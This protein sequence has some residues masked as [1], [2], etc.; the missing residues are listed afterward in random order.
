ML[1]ALSL[2]AGLFLVVSVSTTSPAYAGGP[3][4][5]GTGSSYAAVAINQWAAQALSLYGLSINYETSSSVIGLDD[6][7]QSQVDFG[8]SEI[9]Y[10]TGQA[11]DTPPAGDT[12]QYLPDVAGAECLMYNLNTITGAAVTNLNLDSQVIMGIFSGQIHSWNNSQI[13]ALNPNVALP[14]A[15]I[16]VVYRT[17]AS[18]DNYIFSDYLYTLQQSAWTAYANTLNVPNG[19]TAVWPTPQGS[20]ST[21][22]YT[23]S[24][25]V[26]QSGSDNSSDYVASTNGTIT[27]VETAYAIEHNKPCAYVENSSGNFVKPSEGADAIALTNDQL[28]PDLEQNLTGVFQSPQASAY[29]ISAYSYIITQEQQMPAAKGAVL[30]QFV[31]FVACRGQIAAGELGYSPLPPNL[32]QDDFDAIRRMNGAADPGQVTASN[33]PNPYVTGALA[34]PTGDEDVGV[35][36]G[37]AVVVPSTVPS[38]GSATTAPSGHSTTSGSSAASSTAT[39]SSPSGAT[40]ATT[41]PSSSAAAGATTAT[42]IPAR[43][44]SQGA[45]VPAGAPAGVDLVRTANQVLDVPISVMKYVLWTVLLFVVV[46][47][48]PLLLARRGR[49][50]RRGSTS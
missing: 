50:R 2:L 18:G 36:P 26:G 7:A 43:R 14:S 42:T 49:R 44:T 15:P 35:P 19:A 4:V 30:G 12:Y 3:T 5:T 24:N 31:Q 32:V 25:W 6:F 41:S 22:P 29:P 37:G 27:Y 33:C 45:T 48:P 8:A 9:G 28:Q 34:L 10:S 17:D 1:G 11:D 39:T 23:F 20:G 40:T 46:G 16:I 47:V 21:G 13:A 38:G